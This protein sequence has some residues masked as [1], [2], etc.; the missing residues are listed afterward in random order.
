MRPVAEHLKIIPAT[1]SQDVIISKVNVRAE[2]Y[3]AIKC[4]SSRRSRYLLRLGNW[5]QHQ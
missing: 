4:N 5:G 3:G 1:K 2:V